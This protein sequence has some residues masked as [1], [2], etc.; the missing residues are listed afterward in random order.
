MP[1]PSTDI[2]PLVEL[3]GSPRE[4]GIML[5]RTVASRIAATAGVYADAFGMTL[6]ELEEGGL[7]FREAVAGFCPDHLVEMEG[8][9]EGADLPLGLILAINA[10]SELGPL[11]SE[12]TCVAFPGS[13]WHGQTWD[14]AASLEQL[15]ILVRTRYEDG[16]RTLTMTEPAMLAKVGLS[17]AGVSVCLNAMTCYEVL[18]GVPIHQ[19]LRAALEARTPEAAAAVVRAPR[20]CAGNVLL[21]GAGRYLDVEHAGGRTLVMEGTKGWVHT[22]HYL[23]DEITRA[24][25]P[26]HRSSFARKARADSLLHGPGDRDHLERILEDRQGD[27]PILRPFDDHEEF[28]R[29][30]TVFRICMNPGQGV[31]R[32]AS[33][34]RPTAYREYRLEE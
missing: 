12:C 31:L 4:R 23:G 32:I 3:E 9:A 18:R 28:G 1:D 14:W 2:L 26:R 10:R 25:L 6:A 33:G 15:A 20:G 34:Q 11:A 16:H 22:N 30:G 19:I 8:M 24:D 13:G 7:S 5:G 17:S 21:G 29:Y 27:L